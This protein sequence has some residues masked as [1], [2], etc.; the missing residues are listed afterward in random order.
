MASEPG[1]D[2]NYSDEG[3]FLLGIVIEKV[4]G[5]SYADYMREAFFEPLGMAQTHL[6]DQN[7]IVPH[8]ARGYA[9][10]NGKLERNR[11]VWNFAVTSHFG[12][13]SLLDDMM[14]W[15]AELS[16]P[17]VIDSQARKATWEIQGILDTDESCDTW[18][19]ARGWLV[20]IVDGHPILSHGGYSGTAYLRFIDSGLSVIVL[21]HR[22]DAPGELSPV[23]MAWEIAHAVD[24]S[25]PADGY[26][27]EI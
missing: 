25:A 26:H 22:E 18:G 17:R 20:R 4:T 24:A 10:K 21:S 5:E 12:V 3:Y 27:C 14:R 16:H 23:D 2:W 7:R 11:R 15:E 19:Y 8:L 6:L 13:M 9:W 1:T